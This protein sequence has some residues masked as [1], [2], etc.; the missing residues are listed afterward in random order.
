MSSSAARVV[1]HA[2]KHESPLDPELQNALVNKFG[3]KLLAK[4][5]T[6]IPN[7]LQQ[8]YR[9]V[10]GKA[11]E[12]EIIDEETGEIKKIKKE[13]DV[14]DP[15]TGEVKKVEV[16]PYM[17]CTEFALMIHIW[18]WWWTHKNNPWPTV[19]QLCEFL[20]KSE[21]TVRRYLQRLR[22][23][24]F[25]LHIEQ[26]NAEG[27]QISNR[28][29]FQP[30]LRRLIAYLDSLEQPAEPAQEGGKDAIFGRERMPNLSGTP[31]HFWQGNEEILET[32][33][34]KKTASF[35]S[36][37]AAKAQKVGL[38][39]TIRNITAESEELEPETGYD[40]EDTAGEQGSE[41]ETK[42]NGSHKDRPGAA[43]PAKGKQR[44]KK[45]AGKTNKAPAAPLP[46]YLEGLILENGQR[47]NEVNVPSALSQAANLYERARAAG[48]HDEYT[49][50]TW[51]DYPRET[52]KDR[53][54]K[55]QIKKRNKDGSPA[56]MRL[57][58][59]L[60]RERVE[61]EEK[62]WEAYEAEQRRLDLEEAQRE[63]H[64]EEQRR[65]DAQQAELERDLVGDQNQVQASESQ[66]AEER[67]EVELAETFY[68]Q[69]I[70]EIAA[71]A[72]DEEDLQVS[73]GL[74]SKIYGFCEH[75]YQGFNAAMYLDFIESALEQVGGQY[76]IMQFFGRLLVIL[77]LEVVGDET[78]YEICPVGMLA[79]GDPGQG[80]SKMKR[81][82]K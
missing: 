25:M 12:Q 34:L 65:L 76:R 5:F 51:M 70:E 74:A 39:T 46:I 81:S 17:T 82:E 27:K 11:E 18:T 20:G 37:S 15:E 53:M 30:F 68:L 79:S 3:K 63:A 23:K 33:T 49:F 50:A 52:V 32:E 43:P 38:G 26:Y 16:V 62:Q 73:L 48:C 9:A 8:Y 64:E 6:A 41:S 4:G 19:A 54:E 42:A 31:C 7:L 10:P 45:R 80:H 22:D 71:A 77:Q 29:D 2:T 13:R 61:L 67:G 1:K 60:L 36:G 72:S 47:F 59:H 58:F 69:R 57:F 66:V 75:Y 28:Y 56:G 24:G 44:A 55:G 35:S 14:I 21:R 78:G 40:E